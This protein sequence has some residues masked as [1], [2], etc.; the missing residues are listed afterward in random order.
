[1]GVMRDGRQVIVTP[2]RNGGAATGFAEM[3]GKAETLDDPS[4]EA[5]SQAVWRAL[6]RAV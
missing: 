5:M 4:P 3:P 6:A 1:V 2:K